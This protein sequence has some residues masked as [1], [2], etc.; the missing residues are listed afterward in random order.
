[1]TS[2][3]FSSEV[4]LTGNICWSNHQDQ[5]KLQDQNTIFV[6]TMRLL[7]MDGRYLCQFRL[8]NQGLDLN[9]NIV[10]SI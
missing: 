3:K 5:L 8:Q 6:L 2:V 9:L 10:G 4:V 7:Y 1:M